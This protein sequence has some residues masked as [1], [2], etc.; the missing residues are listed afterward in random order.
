[1]FFLIYLRRE[2]QRRARQAAVIAIGLAVG[3][4]LVLVVTATAAGVKNAQASVLHALYGIGTDVTVTKAPGKP[5]DATHGLGAFSPGKNSQVIDEL[6]GGNLGLVN[7]SYVAR[8]DR[9][10][11][12]AAAAGGLANLTDTKLKVPSTSQ[13]GPGGRPPASALNPVTFSVDGLQ[14]GHLRLGPYAS[15]SITSG[16][17]FTAADSTARVAVVDSYYATTHKLRVESAITLAKK[18]FKVI[19]ITRQAQGGGSAD[20]YI[21]LAAAQQLGLG[22]YGAS[23]Q[24][25][26]NTIYVAA[27]SSADIPAVQKEIAA[28]LPSATVSTSSSLAGAVTGSLASTASLANDLGRWL[29]IA[30]LIAAFAM[31]SLL[32]MA[33]V[34]RRVRE[35]GTLKALGWRSKRIVAQVMGESL[36]VGVA[37]AVLGVALGIGGAAVVNALAPKLWATVGTD[38]GTPAPQNVS[39][40]GGGTTHSAAAGFDHTVAVHLTAPVTIAAIVL[41]VLLAL[42]GGLIAGSLG[43]WRAARLRPAAALSRVE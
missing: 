41:A 17:G 22:P 12:V 1:M 30:V 40:N 14:V 19:G 28:L 2:I 15:G 13:L 43:S 42:A 11:G 9:L 20:V 7:G 36:I 32:T 24:G 4:G 3:I 27:K 21:P 39:L 6:V 8:V 33:A 29:A 16:R 18:P 10:A 23:L 38:P 26:V 5:S 37:G 34:A 31:A 25:Q 35:F